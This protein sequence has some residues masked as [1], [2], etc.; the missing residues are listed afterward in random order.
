VVALSTFSFISCIK[1]V[2]VVK[3][4]RIKKSRSTSN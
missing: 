2:K 4:A 1:L 3:D